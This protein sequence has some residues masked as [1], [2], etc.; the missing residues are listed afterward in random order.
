MRQPKLIDYLLLTI[1]ALIWASA[2]FNIKI[3]TYSFGPITIGS[4]GADLSWTHK[5]YADNLR[6]AYN[7]IIGTSGL[8]SSDFSGGTT[9]Y[10]VDENDA[11][12]AG[13]TV[14]TAQTASI[15]DSYAG[16][17][18]YV[19]F[20]H[21]GTGMFVLEIDDIKIEGCNTEDTDGGGDNGGDDSVND[22]AGSG[23]AGGYSPV[24]GYA[25]AETAGNGAYVAGGGGGGA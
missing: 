12:T 20:Q 14:A 19:A 25:G 16:Q 4:E 17:E 15:S 11:S 2:F 24:E 9:V 1:L 22:S 18:I 7:I 6:N 5:F 3:A 13:D 8:A 10:S 23:N 21:V